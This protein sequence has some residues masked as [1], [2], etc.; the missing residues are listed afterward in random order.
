MNCSTFST[1]EIWEHIP[2][3]E[4]KLGVSRVAKSSSG[5]TVTLSAG[6]WGLCGDKDLEGWPGGG[7]SHGDGGT[8]MDR[9]ISR[10]TLKADVSM[11][12]GP[13]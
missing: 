5:R 6:V 12:S 2:L 10:V 3:G 11:K 13:V 9:G 1:F 7:M 8:D 4:P